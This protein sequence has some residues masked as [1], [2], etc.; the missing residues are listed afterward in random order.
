[1]PIGV[2][3]DRF[4]N[5]AVSSLSVRGAIAQCI[6]GYSWHKGWEILGDI[7]YRIYNAIKAI[8]GN[9][10]WQIARKAW[11][12]YIISVKFPESFT[13]I[14]ADISNFV[15]FALGELISANEDEV[16]LAAHP[17]QKLRSLAAEMHKEMRNLYFCSIGLERDALPAELDDFVEIVPA[18]KCPHDG[19][20][21]I[22]KTLMNINKINHRYCLV[23]KS[24]DDYTKQ[25]IAK[26]I[27]E[28]GH[29][30]KSYSRVRT[31]LPHLNQFN[32][33]FPSATGSGAEQITWF[34][35]DYSI[36]KQTHQYTSRNIANSVTGGIFFNQD[37]AEPLLRL[38][39]EKMAGHAQQVYQRNA[40]EVNRVLEPVLLPEL[41]AIVTE[42]M[43]PTTEE[44]I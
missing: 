42:Y 8:F 15:D 26:I 33:V 35:R 10:D 41:R 36:D 25:V 27:E 19:D 12:D 6:N 22:M 21:A 39:R 14:K 4:I 13:S 28:I 34:V 38:F 29:N 31:A 44:I 17:Q 11:T 18:S 30:S 43:R 23:I 37:N 40:E 9:S 5:S 2:Q 1:M 24:F 7:V 20:E 3:T 32:H 16:N